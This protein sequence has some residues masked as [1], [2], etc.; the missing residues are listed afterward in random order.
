[1]KRFEA[2]G[3]AKDLARPW[4][5]KVHLHQ[6][7]QNRSLKLLSAKVH[8]SE[9]GELNKNL[10]FQELPFRGYFTSSS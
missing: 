5:T 7:K 2:S 8:R 10:A 6:R 1:M 3:S 9:P 4:K